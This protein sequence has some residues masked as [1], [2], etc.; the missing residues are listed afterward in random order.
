ME[1]LTE[2]TAGDGW[3]DDVP[4][5][6]STG[7]QHQNTNITARSLGLDS[8]TVRTTDTNVVVEQGGVVESNGVPYVTTAANS[9]PI[10]GIATGVNYIYL[11]PGGSP[12]EKTLTLGVVDV[13]WVPV[14]NGFYTVSTGY[15]VLN[16]TICDSLGQLTIRELQ[17]PRTN[18]PAGEILKTHAGIGRGGYREA[19]GSMFDLPVADDGVYEIFIVGPGAGAVETAAL[20]TSGGEGGASALLQIRLDRGDVIALSADLSQVTASVTGSFDMVATGRTGG[21]VTVDASKVAVLSNTQ[22]GG[23]AVYHNPT[24]PGVGGLTAGGGGAGKYVDGEAGFLQ[25]PGG[26]DT[27]QIATAGASRVPG[28]GGGGS[29][30]LESE[31]PIVTH[32]RIG[33]TLAY[34]EIRWLCE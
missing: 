15:R 13:E 18:L 30:V 28:F 20:P 34:A 7:Y 24:N 3:V 6:V 5:A 33:Q 19:V 1:I 26:V 23:V 9:F 14:K 31:T 27:I 4:G 25:D 29:R 16:K 12:T 17:P 32:N 22:D 2:N 11:A 21:S 8:T 10:S